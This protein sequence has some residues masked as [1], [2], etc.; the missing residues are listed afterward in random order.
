[1][2]FIPQRQAGDAIG[3]ILQLQHVAHNHSLDSML[4]SLDVNKAFD[5]FFVALSYVSTLPLWIW[6]LIHALDDSSIRLP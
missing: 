6:G 5:T 4:L 1:M 3:K 2:G